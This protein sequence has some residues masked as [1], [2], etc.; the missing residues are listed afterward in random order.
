[1]E[2]LLTIESH[3]LK[4]KRQIELLCRI[5]H[6]LDANYQV[7]QNSVLRVLQG[8]LQAAVLMLDDLYGEVGDDPSV[9]QVMRKKGDL[10]RIKYATLV[11]NRLSNA[12]VELKE[13]HSI[14]D[15]SWFL[16]TALE[17][18]LVDQELSSELPKREEPL[19][20][21]KGMRAAISCNKS[22]K[23]YKSSCF[24][25][26]DEVQ[27]DREPIPYSSS[28]IATDPSSFRSSPMI[29]DMMNLHPFAD[30]NATMKDARNLAAVLSEIAPRTFG[31]LKCRWVLRH[32][33][34]LKSPE[35]HSI[36]SAPV[37]MGLGHLRPTRSFE[38]VFS[39]PEGLSSPRSLR[40]LLISKDCHPRNERF[41]IAKQLAN[42][43]MFVHNAQFVHKN[44][45]PETIIL[46]KDEES[47]LG[48]SFLVGFEKF[49]LV[50]GKTYHQ[51]DSVWQRNLYRYPT[52]QGMRPGD[53]YSMQHDI[54]SLG[55]CLLE[56]GL[57][58]SFVSSLF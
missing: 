19:S 31:L 23:Q 56:V 3:W 52:R 54:Y 44:I 11:K 37:L 10:K 12:V 43:V 47:V 14:F 35:E 7:H 51:G 22:D 32:E 27:L 38:F 34:L 53:D 25:S 45:S 1:M 41:E 8:K 57:W 49:R 2:L 18:R 29:V 15:P 50:D 55:V 24:R 26:A 17:D 5:W 39:I 36:P 16:L 28:Q 9:G 4:M 6:T 13:W 21:L 46:L 40:S 48:K 20:V 42:S 30:E 33:Q 58:S